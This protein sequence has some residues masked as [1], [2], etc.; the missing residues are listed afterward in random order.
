MGISDKQLKNLK[1]ASIAGNIKIQE[2][3]QKRIKE[4]NK[5]PNKCKFCNNIIL[6]KGRYKKFC[7]SSCAAKY[8]NSNRVVSDNTKGKISNSMRLKHLPVKKNV[9]VWG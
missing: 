9:R 6:Y 5:N 2:N 7:N 4:Y 8:N 1:K 3:K